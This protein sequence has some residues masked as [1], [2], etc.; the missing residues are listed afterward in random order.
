[1][2]SRS[3]VLVL[4]LCRAVVVLAKRNTG[5]PTLTAQMHLS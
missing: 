5:T 4:H 1:M 3:R 2:C